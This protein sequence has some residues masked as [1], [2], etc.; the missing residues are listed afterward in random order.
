[1]SQAAG[2]DQGSIRGCHPTSCK[3]CQAARADQGSIRLRG[4]PP[5]SSESNRGGS[6]IDKKG[7]TPPSVS[8]AGEDLGS[9]IHMRGCSSIH[10]INWNK[11][12]K[13]QKRWVKSFDCV[14]VFVHSGEH[15]KWIQLLFSSKVSFHQQLAGSLSSLHFALQCSLSLLF[16]QFSNWSLV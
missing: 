13:T 14:M 6:R 5:T 15:W 16:S 3:H 10:K 4:C 1:M 7:P 9:I 8:Q 12:H 11:T 2:A